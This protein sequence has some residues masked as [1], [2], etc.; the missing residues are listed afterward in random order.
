MTSSAITVDYGLSVPMRDGTHLSADAF[1]PAAPG[2]HPALLMRTPYNKLATPTIGHLFHF[3]VLAAARAGYA[4]VIQDTRG[5]YGSEGRFRQFEDETS[6]G[7]DS[8]A[9]VAAQGWCNGVVGLF[10]GSYAGATQYLAA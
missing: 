3:D 4:V 8:I 5:R 7:A 2:R 6:D 9:W 1:R 10:G